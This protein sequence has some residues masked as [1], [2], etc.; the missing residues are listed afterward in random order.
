VP[1]AE[2]DDEPPLADH[3]GPVV[4]PV[5]VLAGD[6]PVVADQLLDGGVV[7]VGGDR[8]ELGGALDGDP[9]PEVA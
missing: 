2:P 5:V 9:G 1:G 4:V 3:G 7:R 8:G 6:P